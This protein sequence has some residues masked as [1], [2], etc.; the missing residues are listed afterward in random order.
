MVLVFVYLGPTSWILF[1]VLLI[2]VLKIDDVQEEVLVLWPLLS[3]LWLLLQL[4]ELLLI[5][6]LGHLCLTV[7]IAFLDHCIYLMMLFIHLFGQAHL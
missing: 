6:K 5:S 1:F 3:Y 7:Q 4:V 2:R